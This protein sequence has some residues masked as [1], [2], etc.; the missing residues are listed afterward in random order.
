MV[1]WRSLNKSVHLNLL[2]FELLSRECET[3][4]N[5]ANASRC[6]P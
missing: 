3:K 5:A 1:T 4:Q 6:E 2:R